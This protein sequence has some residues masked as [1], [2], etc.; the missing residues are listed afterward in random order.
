MKIQR[1]IKIKYIY[2]Y[3]IKGSALATLPNIGLG[4]IDYTLLHIISAMNTN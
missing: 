4:H 1:N 2:I 3:R